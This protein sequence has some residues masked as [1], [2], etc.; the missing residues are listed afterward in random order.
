MIGRTSTDRA[1]RIA[2]AAALVLLLILPRAHAAA[3][4]TLTLSRTGRAAQSGTETQSGTESS[5][6][7]LADL[8]DSLRVVVLGSST[9]AGAGA[10][11]RDSAWVWRFEAFLKSLDPDFETVNLA[12]G[13]YTTYHIQPQGY[14]PPPDRP[15]TDPGRNITAAIALRP[16]AIIINLPSN[17]A[18]RNFSIIEQTQNFVRIADEAASAR[19]PL[20]VCTTQPRNMTDPQ[21]QNLVTMR[22]WITSTYADHALDFWHG[23][24]TE[25]GNMLAAFNSG[26][27]VHLNDAGHRL[28]FERAR[29]AGIPE[30]LVTALASLPDE[31][32]LELQIYPQPVRHM[33]TFR[34][35]GAGPDSWT[36]VMRDLVGR[37]VYR[38]ED[39]ARRGTVLR[40]FHTGRLPR[41]LY[42]VLLRSGTS[43]RSAHLLLVR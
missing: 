11:V 29:D 33:V 25:T 43:M 37:E 6:H 8:P 27:G 40:Q 22:D 26:D 12:V 2:A 30:R 39:A 13:G 20:W 21:R 28:L 24:A 1:A 32:S 3:Q 23:L 35:S 38:A 31:R 42:H 16:S 41:G 19:I 9:A 7:S 34:I 36:L 5:M 18:A 4:H 10:S 15:A 14:M 17:D